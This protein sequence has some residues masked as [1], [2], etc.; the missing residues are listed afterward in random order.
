MAFRAPT[1]T[2]AH[3]HATPA[4]LPSSWKHSTVTFL[5]SSRLIGGGGG[6]QRA[7][8]ATAAHAL[9]S[10]TAAAP[11]P[12]PNA[13]YLAAEFS[14]HGVT[15]EAVG[16]SCAVKMAVRNGSAAHLLLPSGLV[17]SYKPAMW[18]GAATEV[19]HTTVGEGPGGRPVIRGGVSMDFRC[20]RAVGGG[21]AP[22]PPSS[23]SPGGAWSLRDVRGGPTGSISV[24]LV[25]VE[26][27]GSGDGAEARCVVTLQPEA[28]ASEYAVTNA[29]SSPSAV[30]LSGA[31]CNHL[32]VSTPDATYA[33]GLQGS[34][35][36]GREPLLSEFSILP[37]DYYA[38]APSSPQPRW[39]SKG[40]D[41]L[42][43]GGGGGQSAPRAAPEPD[44]EEDDNYKHL[45]AELC[46]VYRHAPREF[47]VIDR[48]RRNSVC[49][50]RR[51]FEELY[52]FSP[53]SK[54]EWYGKFAYVCIGP[55][56]LEPV[57]L[58]PGATWQ[59][60]QCIRNPN[61]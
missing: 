48:G 55:A 22:R 46:R 54:Y 52:V 3:G 12:P 30:A 4:P 59:G 34:D 58:P 18:H 9:S 40:L 24:E 23:W 44:G 13:E 29:A 25:S 6:G 28:L 17:T 33:V 39:V 38:T 1:A 5:S 57:V 41:M 16:D 56:M 60:A 14:G 36:R 49:L 8:L 31:V 26:P 7:R 53:G 51:G 47:T 10:A 19:L 61:L 32:R 35:Y 21:Q 20:A 37:P 50:S 15:F 45:T 43:S 42:L 27:P 2:T 11:F